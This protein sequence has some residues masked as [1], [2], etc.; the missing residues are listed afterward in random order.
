MLSVTFTIYVSHNTQGAIYILYT[1]INNNS[2]K[3]LC[4]SDN[5]DSVS[6]NDMKHYNKM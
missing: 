2:L 3:I 4:F 5:S 1:I 6:E